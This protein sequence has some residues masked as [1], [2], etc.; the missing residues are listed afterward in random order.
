MSTRSARV[1]GATGTG[2]GPGVLE[3]E[4]RRGHNSQL[5]AVEIALRECINEGRR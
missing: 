3:G 5:P 1:T 4:T 2:G